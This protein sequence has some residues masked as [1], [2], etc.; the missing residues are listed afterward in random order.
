[1]HGITLVRIGA[2]SILPESSAR[3]TRTKRDW[4][5][6]KDTAANP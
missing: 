2:Y 1:M 5:D 3:P 4:E 6:G